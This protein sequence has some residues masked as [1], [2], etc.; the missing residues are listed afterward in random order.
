MKEA[1]VIESTH[2]LEHR[3]GRHLHQTF[4]LHP[5]IYFPPKRTTNPK[6]RMAFARRMPTHVAVNLA[7]GFLRI[8]W[9]RIEIVPVHFQ[10]DNFS[11]GPQVSE[12][13]AKRQTARRSFSGCHHNIV[14]L[15]YGGWIYNQ[16]SCFVNRLQATPFI[17]VI[18]HHTLAGERSRLF[19]A[20]FLA[21]GIFYA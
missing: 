18:Y 4:L 10:D 16:L 12:S 21:E 17:Q 20:I 2:A 6:H 13:E 3:W 14:T 7:Q 1:G 9:E 11:L 15:I 19:N 5:F 8:R